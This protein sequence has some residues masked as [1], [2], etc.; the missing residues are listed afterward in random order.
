MHFEF[1]V[2]ITE[3]PLGRKKLP[4]KFAEF[5]AG[6]KTASV[7]LREDSCGQ[8]RWPVEVL[9]DG[10]GKM[11]LDTGFEKFA[12]IHGLEVGCL[13]LCRYEGDCNMSV[14]VFNDSCCHRH[15]H[16]DDL[17]EDSNGQL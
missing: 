14:S 6:W 9:F 4:N 16:I 5:L 11:Y 15:Y 7:N 8:C 17:G 13:L 1:V 2:Q 12:R 10:Q 3:D